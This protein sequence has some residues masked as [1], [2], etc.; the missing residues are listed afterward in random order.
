MIIKRTAIIGFVLGITVSATLTASAQI[1]YDD[2]CL[3]ALA[4]GSDYIDKL[5]HAQFEE[6]RRSVLTCTRG[7]GSA[8]PK[9]FEDW[10]L[11][12]TESGM[13][14]APWKVLTDDELVRVQEI[15]LDYPHLAALANEV[16]E[17]QE[18]AKARQQQR[19]KEAKKQEEAKTAQKQYVLTQIE[20]AQQVA[21][22][23]FPI[24]DVRA[25]CNNLAQI[26]AM[27]KVNPTGAEAGA[28]VNT[29]INEQRALAE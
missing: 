3:G 13:Y 10:L 15:A 23:G 11:L 2:K 1:A 7:V 28:A 5:N 18:G 20:Q 21:H 29:L 19:E 16:I 27:T 6:F 26:V 12:R 9:P 17:G 22:G 25:E 8:K 4:V 24:L 14:R